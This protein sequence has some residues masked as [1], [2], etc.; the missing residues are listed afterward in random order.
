MT[1]KQPKFVA[2]LAEAH[3]TRRQADFAA[4]YGYLRRAASGDAAI[5]YSAQVEFSRACSALLIEDSQ[6]VAD[7]ADAETYCNAKMTIE[8]EPQIRRTLYAAEQNVLYL[9]KIHQ[10][11]PQLDAE[12]ANIERFTKTLESLP[13]LRAWISK[14]LTR[15]ETAASAG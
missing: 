5:P 1:T 14:Y 6:Q 10:S 11:G 3:K 7:L 15:C 4:Y 8:S 9:Q 13:E 2:L 12:N